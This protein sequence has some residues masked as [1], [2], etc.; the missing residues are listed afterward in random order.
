MHMI[1]STKVTHKSLDD[2]GVGAQ[3]GAVANVVIAREIEQRHLEIA[4]SVSDDVLIA[5][6]NVRKMGIGEILRVKEVAERD[7][8]RGRSSAP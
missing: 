6:E 4:S 2:V 1:E 8:K 3:L 5:S 7:D